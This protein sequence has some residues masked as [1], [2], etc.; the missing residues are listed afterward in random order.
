M[1]RIRFGGIV[2]A[3]PYMWIAGLLL[4]SEPIAARADAYLSVAKRVT[5][6]AG[7]TV[8][9][10][11]AL[12]SASSSVQVSTGHD[13][14]GIDV[15][16]E[17]GALVSANYDTCQSWTLQGSMNRTFTMVLTNPTNSPVEVTINA[18]DAEIFDAA[19]DRPSNF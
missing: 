5:I 2:G 6:P 8:T 14:I 17:G 4:I 16:D 15:Y 9:E 18:N 11:I 7:G 13:M 12:T 1:A 10:E 3:I 19:P